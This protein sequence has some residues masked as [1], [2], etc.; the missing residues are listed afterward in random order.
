MSHGPRRRLLDRLGAS[1]SLLSASTRIHGDIETEGA[2]LL[3][4]HVRGDGRIGA[5]LHIDRHAHWE[6]NLVAECAIVE[7][8]ITG[9]IQVSGQIEIGAA[10]VIEGRVTARRVAIARGAHVQGEITVVDGGELVQFEEKRA[11]PL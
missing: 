1:P 5:E 4:G 7:G 9:S 11:V 2:F 3:S 10:A 6:G 8:R